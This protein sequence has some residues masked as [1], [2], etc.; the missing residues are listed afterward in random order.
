M[1]VKI[2]DVKDEETMG[3]AGSN[4]KRNAATACTQGQGRT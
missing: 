2:V 4:L 3:G 1:E